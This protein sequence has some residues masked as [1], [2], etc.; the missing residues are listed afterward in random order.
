MA[1]TLDIVPDI[2]SQN[3]HFIGKL[4]LRVCGRC[5]VAVAGQITASS[6]EVTLNSS[7]C[8]EYT[9]MSGFR[10]MVVCPVKMEFEQAMSCGTTACQLVS[11]PGWLFKDCWKIRCPPSGESSTGTLIMRS[12]PHTAR[13]YTA[14]GVR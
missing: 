8:W 10:I 13:K 5:E 14:V 2:E 11:S 12:A 3:P 9:T 6:K 1:Q 7:Y 4:T